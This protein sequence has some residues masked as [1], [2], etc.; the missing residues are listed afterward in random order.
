MLKPYTGNWSEHLAAHLLRRTVF[1]ASRATIRRY[2]QMTMQQCVD[3]LL[4]ILPPPPPPLNLSYDADPNVPIGQTW[5]DKA[6]SAGVNP[7]R[8]NSLNS[9]SLRLMYQ[10]KPNIREKMT[11]FW[12]N[13]FVVADIQDPR[14]VYKT[15]ALLRSHALGNFRQLTKDI[16]IDPSMLIYLNG[17]DNTRQAPNENYA[18]ELLEL[19]TLGKGNIAG[20][21]DYTT[22]TENDIMAISKVLTGWV[23]VF[24]AVPI[25]SEFRV[26]RHDTGVKQL[27]HRFSNVVINNNGINEYKDL[28]DII[29]GREE[30]ARF[31]CRKLYTWFV[32]HDIDDEIENGVITPMA[33]MLRAGDYEVKPVIAALLS[34]E[35]FY[36]HCTLGCMVKNP[37]D[38]MISPMNIFNVPLPPDPV[39]EERIFSALY[40]STRSQQ[41]ALF[42]APSVAGWQAYYQAP[43]YDKLWLNAYTLPVRKVYTDTISSAGFPIGSYRL[44]IDP[45]AYLQQFDDPQNAD[46]VINQF[47][48]VL[49]AKPLSA[50]Q[51]E[52]LKKIL[53]GVPVTSWSVIYNAYAADPTNN[54]KKT[55]VNNRLRPLLVYMMRMPEIHLS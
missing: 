50:N 13:H 14:F 55:A 49:F 32:H 43:L 21:G 39:L 29:F 45:A 36:T 30:V 10:Q 4:E 7:Y 12:H 20:P 38:F 40:V 18:R 31:I 1:G 47:A 23:I 19:F 3:E 53:L 6:T 37:I 46:S 54:T 33:E 35:H 11:L 24:T 42:E 26:S 15:M 5:V 8:R 25:R 17:N 27:S 9:W 2:S 52:E 51:L 34:S 28:I 16:T 44:Q 22:Y 48:L 41:M